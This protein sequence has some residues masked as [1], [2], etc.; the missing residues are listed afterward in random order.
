MKWF[1]YGDET[2]SD[3]E[4]MIAVPSI[5]IG[6]GILSLPRFIAKD[7]VSSDG[8]ITLAI[9]G[10]LFIGLAWL[11][12]KLASSYPDQ[13]FVEYAGSLVT[14]PIAV[15]LTFL[16]AVHGLILGA[17]VMRVIADIAKEY[18]FDRTP[19]E[20][21]ALSFLLV[22]VYAISG[23][24]A[25]L[26]RLNMMFFPIII[27]IT[28]AVGLFAIAWFDPKN[29]L[30]VFKTDF[31]GYLSSFKSSSF[32]FIGSGIILFYTCL[33]RKPKKVPKMAALG[34]SIVPGL[35]IVIYLMCIGVFGNLVTANLSYPIIELAKE[36]EIPGGFF[37]RF[38]SIFFVIW[39]MSIFNTMV[40]AFD[41]SVFAF[42]SI[43]KWKKIQ[44]IL[45]L[46]PIVYLMGMFPQDL[47][48]VVRF[49][50]FVSYYGISVTFFVTIGLYIIS[51][52]KRRKTNAK[53]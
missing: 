42:E 3:K 18:L 27:F 15:I 41:V 33:V 31:S 47:I 35:Y 49:G 28:G 34:M 37:E 2:I 12:A 51:T 1:E 46:T 22:V 19:V 9:S 20:V 5:T 38:D 50:E 39:I 40:M 13:T 4:L 10:I 43:F 11:I 25:G 21:I 24:R 44:L 32:S 52:I 29:Y 23:S 7:T 48:A 6:V 36:I 53:A 8:W 26:F 14:K 30:P 17:Y 16:L 45:V